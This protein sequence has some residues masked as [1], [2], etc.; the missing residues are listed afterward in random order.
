[1]KTTHHLIFAAIV[2]QLAASTPAAV[3][4][5]TGVH[6]LAKPSDRAGA[7][8]LA[9]GQI[10]SG[11]DDTKPGTS[12]EVGRYQC[13]P[14]YWKAAT[15]LPLSAALNP[16]TSAAVCLAIIR[17]RTGR[18]AGELT[19][20]QFAKAWHRPYGRMTPELRDYIKRFENLLTAQ[21]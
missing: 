13:C 10:D 8:L 14:R 18:D 16:I 20:E 5:E 21:K 12:G 6:L 17:Q 11:N 19:P 1:M 2:L 9:L 7:Y 15:S 4:S 3:I